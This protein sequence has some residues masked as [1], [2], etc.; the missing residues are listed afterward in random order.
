[1]VKAVS[2]CYIAVPSAFTPNND[3]RNDYLYPLNA[4]KATDLQF[5]IFN[6][7]GQVVFET[8]DPAKKWDGTIRGI[9]Q[10][11]GNYVWTLNY[12]ESDTGKRVS[13]KGNSMLIR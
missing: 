7:Y 6:R 13:E 2:S 10:P 4:F 9:P 12:T 3:G 8:T 5:R 1:M 11:A